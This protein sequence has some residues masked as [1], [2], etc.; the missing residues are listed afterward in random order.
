MWGGPNVAQP[1]ECMLTAVF[2]YC[3]DTRAFPS[4]LLS[5]ILRDPISLFIILTLGVLT[6]IRNIL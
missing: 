3:M 5:L 1:V 2:N 4:L 6:Y